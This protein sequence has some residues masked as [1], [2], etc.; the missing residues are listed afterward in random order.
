MANAEPNSIVGFEKG[1]Q[2][3]SG[4]YGHVAWVTSV[5]QRADGR[6]ISVIEMNGWVGDGGGFNKWNT[7]T[8]KQ[9]QGMSYIL[10]PRR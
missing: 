2:G 7:R 5:E 10:A 6:Y 8:V 9:V 4:T 1:I 3:A